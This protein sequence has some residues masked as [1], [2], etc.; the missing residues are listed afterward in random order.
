MTQQI[1]L[2]ASA[3]N[4]FKSCPMRF[5]ISYIQRIRRDKDTDAQRQGT[6]WHAL[7]EVY[8]EN[9]NLFTAID[10]PEEAH[11]KA[12]AAVVQYLNDAYAKTPG[13]KTAEEWAVERTI[14]INS[15]VGYLW[16]YTEF[17]VE[18]V[19]SELG[20]EIDIPG[21]NFIAPGFIDE[22]I[23]L[24][25][26]NLAIRE[27]KST[28]K[29]LDSDS[30]YWN[31][32]GM[33]TQV[34]MYLWAAR[35]LQKQGSL[36]KYGIMADDPPINEIFYDVW[37]KP[38]IKPKKLTQ[39]DSKKFVADGKY[40]GQEFTVAMV[41]D[42]CPTG[43]G[44]HVDNVRAITEPGAKEGTFA[45]HETP[46]MYGARLMEDISKRPEFYYAQREIIRTDDDMERFERELYKIGATIEFM[47]KKDCWFS[48]ENSCHAKWK[49]DYTDIC[50]NH[51]D[52]TDGVVPPGFKC[53]K[54]S[55]KGA[56]NA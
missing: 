29:S 5:W 33:D 18:I 38:T 40:C 56:I 46:E 43:G 48:N 15:F 28:S 19:V 25:D 51:V 39:G 42:R 21:T 24:P 11:D 53:T 30:D 9:W 45:I 2:S 23:R 36:E 14:L 3:I 49:C 26:G 12:I 1:R 35:L 16:Y 52:L 6:N 50:Y 44:W 41:G 10:S 20:F 32:L 13:Y 34:S 47:Q 22:I 37:H 7:H 31:N 55:K 4:S 54:K 17:N 8:S 27:R